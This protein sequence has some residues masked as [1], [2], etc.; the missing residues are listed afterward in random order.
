MITKGNK[1]AFS[2]TKEEKKILEAIALLVYC[3]L[4][5]LNSILKDG[6]NKDILK[7]GDKIY[8]TRTN[9]NGSYRTSSNNEL[10]F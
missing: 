10:I 4:K 1:N 2:L 3:D 7:G 6:L 5:T 8:D 9:Y